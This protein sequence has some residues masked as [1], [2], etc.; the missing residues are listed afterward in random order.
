MFR[1]ILAVLA[2]VLVV[3]FGASESPFGQF[4]NFAT[5]IPTNISGMGVPSMPGGTPDISSMT[6]GWNNGSLTNIPGISGIPGM[7]GGR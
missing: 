6:N 2:S 3:A 1:F 7:P 4:G 5:G